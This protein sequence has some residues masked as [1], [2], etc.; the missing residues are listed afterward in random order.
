[1]VKDFVDS[2]IISGSVIETDDL[3]IYGVL[4]GSNFIHKP[5]VTKNGSKTKELFP[6]VHL[7][8][9]N[10]KRFILGTHHHADSKYLRLY[11][12]EYCYRLNRRFHEDDLFEYL[13]K[14]CLLVSLRKHNILGFRDKKSRIISFLKLKQ[15]GQWRYGRASFCYYSCI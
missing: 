2:K 15:I 5:Y 4:D 3:S 8:I 10:L 14:A 13:L 6:W 9:G 7:V 11:V 12:S 1:M